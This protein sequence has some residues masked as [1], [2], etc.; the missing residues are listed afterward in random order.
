[1]CGGVGLLAVFNA[2][3]FFSCSRYAS[4]NHGS[5]SSVGV[6]G[7]RLASP[8]SSERIRHDIIS[9]QEF[10]V[11]G[12]SAAPSC[13]QISFAC[14]PLHIPAHVLTRAQPLTHANDEMCALFMPS[15]RNGVGMCAVAGGSMM[16]EAS[17]SYG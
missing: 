9:E 13:G 1:M 12:M 15:R 7:L 16:E 6:S 8:T 14:A 3:F 5:S 11:G 4:A 10:V 2:P 17:M